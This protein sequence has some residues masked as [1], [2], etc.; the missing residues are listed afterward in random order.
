MTR[1]PV[2]WLARLASGVRPDS[3]APVAPADHDAFT[4]LLRRARR[5]ELR[6]ARRV[7][8]SRR[9]DLSLSE[10]QVERLSAA[11]DA[12]EAAGSRRALALIDGRAV[13][14]DVPARTID[15]AHDAG[16]APSVL[17]DIDA[18]CIAPAASESGAGDGIP[19]S[20]FAAGAAAHLNH[21]SNRSMAEILAGQSTRAA[22]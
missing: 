14:L 9:L 21:V 6:S 22:L 20:S 18:V 19:F 3:G 16:D 2:K 17:T 4:S 11:A 5:G 8:I 12:A 13:A 1:N 10:D 7:V 15:H